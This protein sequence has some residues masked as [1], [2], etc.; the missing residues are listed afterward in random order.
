MRLGI[1]DYAIQHELCL[2]CNRL[3]NENE[4]VWKCD[5]VKQELK[6]RKKEK[7]REKRAGI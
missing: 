2:G 5:F 6:E 3:L 7:D 1:C 4:I